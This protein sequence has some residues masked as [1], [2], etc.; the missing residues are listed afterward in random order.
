MFQ[1]KNNVGILVILL[2]SFLESSYLNEINGI[3]KLSNYNELKDIQVERI[4]DRNKIKRNKV[5]DRVYVIG[6]NKPFTGSAIMGL[7]DN[8]NIEGIFFYKDGHTEKTAYEYY[9]NNQLKIK[10]PQRNDKNEGRGLEYYSSGKLQSDRFYRDDIMIMC[11]EY[12]ENGT[13]SSIYKATNG[14]NG[15]KTVYYENGKDVKTVIE[16]TQDYSQKGRINDILNGKLKR[17][18]KQ[19]RLQGV[20]TFKNN[21][22]AGLPQ[23]LYYPN[24]KVRYYSIAKNNDV[25]HLQF[26]QKAIEYYDNG[27]EKENCDEV[28]SGMWICKK[29]DKNGKFKGEVQKGGQP[30]ETSN[31]WANFFM[32]VLNILLQ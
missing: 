2:S 3:K 26:T 21:S 16:I 11:N 4:I 7:D 25:N 23:E 14:L 20:F 28:D 19:G 22:L 12:R 1:I 10:V 18:D 13:L 6:E 30:I 27:Q 8:K 24:G 17:Y 5:E 29:Y 31:F 32:G 9:P 15:I